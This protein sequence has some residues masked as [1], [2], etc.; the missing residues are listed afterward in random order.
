MEPRVI[1]M[2][3]GKKIGIGLFAIIILYAFWNGRNL[4][5]GPRITVTPPLKD[6]NPIIIKGVAK[7]VSFLSLNGRQ[8]FVDK[9]GNFLEDVLLL[10]GY[11]IITIEGGDRFGKE[12]TVVLKLYK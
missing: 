9:D 4:I 2:N 7:N 10:P 11:N 6:V 12:K 8:I 5:L 1:S 3:R